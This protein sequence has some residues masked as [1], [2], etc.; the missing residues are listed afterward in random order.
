MHARMHTHT[1]GC[2]FWVKL[3]VDEVFSAFFLPIWTLFISLQHFQALIVFQTPDARIR[4]F[5]LLSRVRHFLC[6]LASRTPQKLFALL[7]D[8]VGQSSTQ[9][10]EFRIVNFCGM[11]GKAFGR[12]LP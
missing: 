5:S 3:N 4:S 10:N 8:L 1:L 12:G 11:V 2:P 9:R 6:W 7:K